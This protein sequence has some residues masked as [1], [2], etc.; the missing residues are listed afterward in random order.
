MT[1]PGPWETG[2]K[3]E[4]LKNV[5]LGSDWSESYIVDLMDWH[6]HVSEGLDWFVGNAQWAFKDFG[7]PLRPE[8]PIPYVNQKGLVDRAGNPKDAYYVYKSYWTT[9]PKFCYIQSHTW[10]ERSGP[11][12]VARPVRVYSNCDTVELS[13]NGRSLGKKA[14]D[15][16]GYPAHGLVWSVPFE[17]GKNHLVATGYQG[18]GVVARDTTSLLYTVRKNGAAERLEVTAERMPDGRTIVTA[19]A[20]DKDGLRC[21]D[22]NKRVYFA[23]DGDGRLVVAQGTP[24]GSSVIEMANGRARIEYVGPEEGYAVI[25]ARNMDFKGSYII[26]R[27]RSLGTQGGVQRYGTAM[28]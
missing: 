12:G 27:G 5:S 19:T 20:V 3:S 24:T 14:R 13:V 22:Y 17:E 7:T 21:L 9:T 2:F 15:A 28:E 4:R 8:N 23:M 10:E 11:T 18:R 16:R 26:I 25:E 1:T 6:L